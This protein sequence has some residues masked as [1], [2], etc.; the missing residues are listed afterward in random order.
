MKKE[1]GQKERKMSNAGDAT[2]DGGRISLSSFR[3]AAKKMEMYPQI[4]AAAG[5]ETS[6]GLV[7]GPFVYTV[8]CIIIIIIVSA[9]SVY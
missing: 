2:E 7:W 4:S 5:G 3:M 9:R 8:Y 1:N 6:M